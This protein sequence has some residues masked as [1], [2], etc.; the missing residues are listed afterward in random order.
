VNEVRLPEEKR[1]VHRYG[2]GRRCGNRRWQESELCF[3]HDP[4]AAEL[5]KNAGRPPSCLKVMTV[6][7]IQETLAGALEELREGRMAPGQAYAL[8]Y[9]AQL[10][11]NNMNRADEE[12]DWVRS[13]WDRYHREI[14]RRVRG[15]D[16]GWYEEVYG[17]AEESEGEGE[18]GEESEGREEVKSATEDAGS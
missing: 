1:C 9:L 14:Y 11:V 6:T 7:E 10:L 18:E 17:E 8:G 13:Q 12:Y 5:R 4:E 2:D 3:Q 15:L 16:E